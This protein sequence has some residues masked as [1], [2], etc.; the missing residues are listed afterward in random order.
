MNAP[1]Y[2]F[3]EGGSSISVC[4]DSINRELDSCYQVGGNGSSGGGWKKDF[5]EVLPSDTK[6]YMVAKLADGARRAKASITNIT[7]TDIE[8]NEVCS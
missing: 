3:Q 5:M 6:F 7:L 4:Q 1:V 2:Y 8:N